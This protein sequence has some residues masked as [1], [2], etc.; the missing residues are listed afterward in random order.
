[1]SH[2][3]LLGWQ[4]PECNK[5]VLV[6]SEAPPDENCPWEPYLMSSRK[7]YA[8]LVESCEFGAALS[9][10]IER[11]DLKTYLHLRKAW[12]ST[13]GKGVKGWLRLCGNDKLF[14]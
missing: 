7:G 5:R 14:Q 9:S 13:P 10:A 1:M 4:C 3:L 11:N 8:H 6:V 12:F 2:T